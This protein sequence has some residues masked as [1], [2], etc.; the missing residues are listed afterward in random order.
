MEMRWGTVACQSMSVNA[1]VMVGRNTVRESGGKKKRVFFFYAQKRRHCHQTHIPTD[2]TRTF[3]FIRAGSGAE[4][5]LP[6]T[7]KCSN[8]FQ[9]KM[10]W[11]FCRFGRQEEGL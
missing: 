7:A 11:N 10:S 3:A 5:I 1:S 9:H 8:V 6:K 2:A 4:G